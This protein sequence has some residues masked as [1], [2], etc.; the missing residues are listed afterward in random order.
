MAWSGRAP[1]R[2][3]AAPARRQRVGPREGQTSR[4]S[5]EAESE[6][7]EVASPSE[8]EAA[9][10]QDATEDGGLQ[11]EHPHQATYRDAEAVASQVAAAAVRAPGTG[12]SNAS[13]EV[14]MVSQPMPFGINH[15]A[16]YVSDPDAPG[17]YIM[18]D[19]S[20]SSDQTEARRVAQM[21]VSLVA[22]PVRGKA[23]YDAGLPRPGSVTQRI[24]TSEQ[25]VRRFL[26]RASA[27]NQSSRWQWY[28]AYTNNCQ[29][30]TSRMLDIL[31]EILS[32]GEG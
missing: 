20:P 5:A 6:Q 19:F 10:Q 8:A 12:N 16:L 1:G 28:R 18:L 2:R 3:T 24:T 17:T 15:S 21:M 30:H 9:E 7:A 13:S 32:A 31:G 14:L 11:P 27:E 23:N 29:D 22:W 4:G 25:I 26:A